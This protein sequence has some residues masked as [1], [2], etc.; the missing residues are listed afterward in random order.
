MWGPG[1]QQQPGLAAHPSPP[2]SPAA[3]RTPVAG[4]GISNVQEAPMPD[5]YAL[6]LEASGEVT[7]AHPAN[8]TE[9]EPEEAEE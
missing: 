1:G 4:G 7:P 8:D 6:R 9:P 2:R 3:R 5:E